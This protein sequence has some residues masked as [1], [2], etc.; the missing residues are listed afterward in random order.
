MALFVVVVDVGTDVDMVDVV[1]VFVAGIVALED[2]VMEVP[3]IPVE[4][5]L[6]PIPT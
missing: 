5:L 2:L 1:S 3:R 6:L 4:A